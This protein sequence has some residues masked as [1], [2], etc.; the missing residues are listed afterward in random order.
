[1]QHEAAAAGSRA[2]SLKAE[3]LRAEAELQRLRVSAE[4][5][6]L[7]Q[8]EATRRDSP[9]LAPPAQILPSRPPLALP[10]LSSSAEVHC[11]MHSCFDYS[12]CSL[13]SG[14]PV[15]LYD[16]DL[17]T[18]LANSEVDGFLKTTLRQTLGYNVHL[19]SN[20]KEACVYL[21]LIGEAF[22]SDKNVV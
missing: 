5:A 13:T 6:R 3:H 16:P 17:Y 9:E 7:A 11:R 2:E 4:Q 10:P 1:M 18:P 12:R 15:Y 20:P 21:V 8:M 22:P 14:F 19:T